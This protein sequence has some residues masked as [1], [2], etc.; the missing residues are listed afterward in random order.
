MSQVPKDYLIKL[1]KTSVI[2]NL[3]QGKTK[4]K[5]SLSP[6]IYKANATSVFHFYTPWKR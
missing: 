3:Q 4:H 1:L 6:M 2:K 5:R